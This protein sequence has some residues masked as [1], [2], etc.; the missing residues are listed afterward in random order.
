MRAA[1]TVNVE[2]ERANLRVLE[3]PRYRK[4][5]KFLVSERRFKK[6]CK[7]MLTLWIMSLVLIATIVG[8]S[9][10]FITAQRSA[11]VYYTTTT[12]VVEDHDTLWGI[13]DDL[14]APY[15]IRKVVKEIRDMNN[16]ESAT[17]YPGEVLR[18]PVFN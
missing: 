2:T 12:V 4:D 3:N 10:Y 11:L 13:A 15:D 18:V 16:L 14:D 17:I 8:T 5:K 9:V 7:T 1:A 6:T